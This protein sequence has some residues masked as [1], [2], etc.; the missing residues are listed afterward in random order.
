MSN[1]RMTV[2]EKLG[3]MWEFVAL[4]KVPYQNVPEENEE[5][6][7]TRRKIKLMTS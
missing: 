7:E 1:R 2:S 6:G 4:F 3:R 5:N